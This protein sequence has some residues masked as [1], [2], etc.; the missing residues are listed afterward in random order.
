MGKKSNRAKW[1]F[2]DAVQMV[3]LIQ[4]LK[5]IAD[6]K[7]YMLQQQKLKFRRFGESFVEFFRMIS[8]TKAKHP[9][10]SNNNPVV[11]ILVITIDGSFLGDFNNKIMRLGIEE[12]EKH[13]QAKF[14]CVG[15][16]GID[17]LKQFT[18]DMKTF[19]NMEKFGIYETAVA[20][21]DYLIDEVMNGRMGKVIV[22]HTFPKTFDTQRPRRVKL[23]PCDELITKQTQFATE[24]SNVLE[25]SEPKEI[26]GFL[27]NLWVTTRIYEMLIDTLIASAA[28]QAKFLEDSVE[29][30]KKER[31]K[32]AINFRKAKKSDIDS[33]LRET[34]SARMVAQKR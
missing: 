14:V 33:S 22:C 16:K 26:I 1:D 34:F 23:L 2:I 30:M 13:S 15:E 12:Y 18:P 3:D 31:Q 32:S 9:L 19:E 8:M 21:K 24:F 7:F 5:D 28:A 10:I 4:T 20:V 11:G 29:K 27:S 6:N 17:R 25:E